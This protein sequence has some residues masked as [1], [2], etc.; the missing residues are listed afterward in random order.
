MGSQQLFAGLICSDPNL[1]EN[2]V[3]VIGTVQKFKLRGKNSINIAVEFPLYYLVFNFKLR[4][5]AA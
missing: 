4:L 2:F 5:K 3:S 1:A